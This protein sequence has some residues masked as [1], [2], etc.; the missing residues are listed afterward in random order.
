RM[1]PPPA[2]N[3]DAVVAANNNQPAPRSATNDSTTGNVERV[4]EAAASDNRK[5]NAQQLTVGS[6]ETRRTA[7]RARTNAPRLESAG[8]RNPKPSPTPFVNQPR[9]RETRFEAVKDDV[10]GVN[11]TGGAFHEELDAAGDSRTA[12]HVEQAEML[13]R[14]FRNTRLATEGTRASSDIAYEKRQSKKLLYQ[15]IVL[16]REAASTGNAPVESLLDSLEPILIDIANLPDKP[17]PDDVRSINERMRKKNLVAM[18]QVNSV[19]SVA[20]SY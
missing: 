5:Q 3:R 16:R 13:L 9:S 17:A 8:N 15:N 12:Q 10:A 18:L 4:V 2:V 14:S 11:F 6:R 19:A 20:R 7:E 1:S